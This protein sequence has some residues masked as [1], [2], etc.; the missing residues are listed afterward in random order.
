MLRELGWPLSEAEIVERFVG[1]SD[2]DA[3]AMNET[4]LGR[5]LPPGW[6]D[7]YAPLYEQLFEA[8]LTPV[9]GVVEALD[10]IAVPTCIASSG[11][12]EYLRFVLGVTGLYG[13]F[14]GRIFSSDD[15]ACGKPA[16]DLF[17]FAAE[18]MGA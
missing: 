8:E 10:A 12:H 1:R 18:R 16:P 2:R 11:T 15:V 7:R 6:R 17:L 5:K 4:H 13:R 14:A 9:D 3:E